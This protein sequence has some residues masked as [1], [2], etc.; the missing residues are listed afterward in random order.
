MFVNDALIRCVNDLD[1]ITER[2][3]H[4]PEHSGAFSFFALFVM[5]ILDHHVSWTKGLKC[6]NFTDF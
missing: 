5:T 2:L 3:T 1:G 4:P 6:D